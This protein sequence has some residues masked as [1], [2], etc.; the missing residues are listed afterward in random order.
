MSVPWELLAPFIALA[1]TAAAMQA[2]VALTGAL[3]TRDFYRFEGSSRESLARQFPLTTIDQ[4][5]ADDR[6]KAITP[7]LD[8]V[9]KAANTAQTR[10]HNVVARGAGCLVTAFIALVLSTMPPDESSWLNW[11][12]LNHNSVEYV[13]AWL[14]AI[15]IV[16]VLVLYLYASN[17]NR[18]WITA[19]VGTELLRQYR[20]STCFFRT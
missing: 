9:H 10:Y 14:D 2:A 18:C 3:R 16:F 5:S 15:T 17:A 13:L 8:A 7:F 4:S 6:R 20:F 12:L 19:R 1:I 11:S